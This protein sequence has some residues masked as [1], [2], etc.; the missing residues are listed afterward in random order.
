MH[1]KGPPK[2]SEGC[3]LIL[4]RGQRKKESQR[5]SPKEAPNCYAGRDQSGLECS[6][7][8]WDF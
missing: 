7:D 1:A 3:P 8:L 5:E 4:R 6:N 2:T